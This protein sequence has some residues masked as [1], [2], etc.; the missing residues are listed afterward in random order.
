METWISP[1]AQAF[2]VARGLGKTILQAGNGAENRF[3][4]R[5]FVVIGIQNEILV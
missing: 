3:S 4:Q 1:G 5:Q 2:Y